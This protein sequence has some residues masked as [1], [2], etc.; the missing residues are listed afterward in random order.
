MAHPHL[1]DDVKKLAGSSAIYAAGTVAVKGFAFLLLPLYT[2]YL[3][4]AHFGVIAFTTALSAALAIVY[5]LNLYGSVTYFFFNSGAEEQRR[6]SIGTVWITMVL[7]AVA[8]ALLLDWA[9]GYFAIS[10]SQSVAFSPYLRLALWIALVNV[11]SLV[12]LNLLQI[13]EKPVR[14]VGITVCAAVVTTVL[15]VWFIVFRKEGAYGLLL[16]TLLGGLVMAAPYLWI[17]ARRIRFVIDPVHLRQALAYSLPL[18]LHSFGGW[19]LEVSD[20]VILERFVTL[21][22]LGLYSIGYLLASAVFLFATTINNGLI[23]MVFRKMSGDEATA[24]EGIA[25]LATYYAAA[26]C[27]AAL[28]LILL[29]KALLWIFTV[30]AFYGSAQIMPWVAAGMLMHALYLVPVNLLIARGKTWA[31]AFVTLS[32]GLLN[33]ALNL[34]WVSR[35]GIMGAAFAT[36]AGYALLL[37][38][39]WLAAQRAYRLRYEYLR[40]GTL[41]VAAAALMFAA[42]MLSFPNSW[43]DA[44][45]RAALW[46]AFPFLLLAL[47]FYHSGEL[48]LIPRLLRGQS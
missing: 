48:R 19:L 44:L 10:L 28:G 16:G 39:V 11:L 5:T 32:S 24:K 14:Y 35:Y 37:L 43:G 9:G 29:S 42:N 41:I 7:I 25:R 12:P 47:R 2:R 46:L 40:L 22:Q 18:V 13:E 33:V 23:P 3:T 21:E 8:V 38:L 36:V 26:V 4:P 27:W 17:V 34:W 15:V 20:R 30:P 31:I 1:L 45:W 6:R